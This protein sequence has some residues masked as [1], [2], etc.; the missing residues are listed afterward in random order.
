MRYFLAVIIVFSSLV[1]LQ[2]ALA[3]QFVAGDFDPADS[4]LVNTYK[5]AVNAF[6]DESTIVAS[7]KNGNELF[8]VMPISLELA[9]LRTQLAVHELNS[10][11]P[12]KLA[13]IL[14]KANDEK[15]TANSFELVVTGNPKWVGHDVAFYYYPD[16]NNCDAVQIPTSAVGDPE[17]L[18]DGN[19]RAVW[20]VKVDSM[21]QLAELRIA[22]EVTLV[23]GQD[24]KSIKPIVLDCGDWRQY[25]LFDLDKDED[26]KILENSSS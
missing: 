19:M 24:D 22:S 6:I 20:R 2:T 9:R 16:E 18:K 26:E 23:I 7:D 3:R 1:W 11:D 4:T 13:E 5:Q 21:Q 12:A 15:P 25:F 8:R 10:T 17:T 14:K